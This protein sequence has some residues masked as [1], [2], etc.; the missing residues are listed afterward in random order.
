MKNISTTEPVFTGQVESAESEQEFSNL[1]ESEK[2]L[3]RVFRKFPD[4]E[5]NNM[6]LAF[7]ISYKKLLE[8]YSEY[9]DPDQ[10]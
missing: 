8:F 9:A 10:K 2:R 7:E 5:A 4:V 6:L 1:S 3:I